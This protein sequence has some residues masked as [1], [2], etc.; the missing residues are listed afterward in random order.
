MFSGRRCRDSNPFWESHYNI[1]VEDIPCS[2]LMLRNDDNS[3]QP[4]LRRWGN[5]VRRWYF[6]LEWIVF[7]FVCMASVL[8]SACPTERR[9]AKRRTRWGRGDLAQE[10]SFQ[11]HQPLSTLMVMVGN[12]DWLTGKYGWRTKKRSKCRCLVLSWRERETHE[13]IVIIIIIILPSECSS[14][15]WW[16]WCSRNDTMAGQPIFRWKWTN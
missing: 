9:R 4:H 12:N 5:V 3:S 2:V 10:N 7:L 1:R 14:L 6:V 11:C 16:W 15:R 13:W 8:F